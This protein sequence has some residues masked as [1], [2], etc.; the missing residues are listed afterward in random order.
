[1]IDES[2]LEILELEE[3]RRDPDSFSAGRLISVALG[4]ALVS[5]GV[6]YLYQQLSPERKSALKKQASGLIAK[7]IHQLTDFEDDDEFDD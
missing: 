4:G 3:D 2:D 7:Q 5:L 6:Y 1:M